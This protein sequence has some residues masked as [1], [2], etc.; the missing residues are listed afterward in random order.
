MQIRE[1]RGFSI[2]V[3]KSG[4]GHVSEVYRKGKLIHTI[5]HE[6]SPDGQ[7]RDPS[8]LIEDA[9]NWIDRTYPHGRIK[10]FGEV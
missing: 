7:F 10:Y 4:A 1:Y 3:Y 9:R 6:N 5:H 2:Q 8:L